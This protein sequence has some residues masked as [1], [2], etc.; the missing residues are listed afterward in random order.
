MFAERLI[1]F[2]Y[3]KATKINTNNNNNKDKGE[4]HLTTGY[5]G[6]EGEKYSS[7]LSLTSTLDEGG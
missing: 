3:K 4:V 6:P 5:E 1:N 7:T 2:L